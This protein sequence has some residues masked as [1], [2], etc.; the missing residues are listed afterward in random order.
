MQLRTGTTVPAIPD[1]LLEMSRDPRGA[2]QSDRFGIPGFE[3]ICLGS[4]GSGFHLGFH[5][6]VLLDVGF[7]GFRSLA[8]GSH[9]ED[10]IQQADGR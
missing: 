8:V 5:K 3:Q 10:H 2:D 6:N 1:M 7:P 4:L 9:G